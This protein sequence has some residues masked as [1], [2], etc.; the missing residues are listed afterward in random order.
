MTD[1]ADMRAKA[2]TR[3]EESR[4]TLTRHEN[5]MQGVAGDLGCNDQWIAEIAAKR[6]GLLARKA[7]AQTAL[8]AA[9]NALDLAIGTMRRR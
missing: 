2:I 7:E 1:Y 5:H 9:T 6:D 3:L 4:A 8:Q